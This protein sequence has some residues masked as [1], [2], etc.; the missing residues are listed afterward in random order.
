MS[1]LTFFSSRKQER[2]SASAA[3]ERLQII[4]ARERG[5]GGYDFLP[6]LQREIIAIVA[7]YVKMPSENIEVKLGNE[8]GLDVLDVSVQLPDAHA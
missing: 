1:L 8:G 4:V 7:K 3:K 5:G 2:S 6:D